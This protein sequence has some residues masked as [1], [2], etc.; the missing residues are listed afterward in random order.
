MLL[1]EPE[2]T[3]HIPQPISKINQDFLQKYSGLVLK[4]RTKGIVSLSEDQIKSGD[5]FGII[6]MDGLD[7]MLAWAMGSTTGH[8][9]IGSFF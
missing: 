2:I 4:D 7:P 3:K 5:A 1:F 9:T 8:M 6:R